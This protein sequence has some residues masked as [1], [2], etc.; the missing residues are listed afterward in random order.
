MTDSEIFPSSYTTYRKDRNARGGGVFILVHSSLKSVSVNIDGD[1]CEAVWCRVLLGDGT[2]LA[3]GSFYRPPGSTSPVSFFQLSNTLLTLHATYIILAGDFNMP[4]VEW[5]SYQPVICTSSLLYT[6]FREMINA[7]SL[8]QFVETPTRLGATSANVLDLFF[9]N[10]PNLVS[11]VITLP[12]ISDHDVVLAKLSY[13]VMK[14]QHTQ[15]RKVYFYEKGDYASLSSELDAFFPEFLSHGPSMNVDSFWNLFKTKILSLTHTFIPSRFIS[16]KRRDDKRWMNR[17]LRVMVN[18]RK[19][20][21]R[22]YCDSPALNLYSE[23]KKQ[24]KNLSKEIRK[25]KMAYLSTL[26]QRLK[27]NP[28]EVWK[29]VKSNRNTGV[30]LPEILDGVDYGKDS[31]GKANCFNLYFQSVFSSQKTRHAPFQ[32]SSNLTRMDDIEISQRGIMLL[33]QKVKLTSAPGPD[34]ISNYI[35]KNCAAS[36]APYLVVLFQKSLESGELPHDWKSANVVPIHK[37]GDRSKTCNYRPISLTSVS[38]KIL[39]HVIYT[40]LISHLQNNNFFCPTQHGFR[41]GFSCETQLVEFT[42]DISASLNSAGQVDCIFLDFRKAFDL[43]AHDLLLQKL[44]LLNIPTTLLTWIEAYL[45]ERK[46]CVVCDGI[47]SVSVGVTSG[48]PQ[49]SVLGPLLFLIF[50]NDLSDYISSTVRL[51]ADDCCVY[52]TISSEADAVTLQHDLNSVYSWCQKWNM[53]LNLSKCNLVRFTKKKQFLQADYFLG[54]TEISA[55]STYKYLGVIFSTDLSWNTH[56]NYIAAKASRTLNFLR[57]NFKDAPVKLKETLYISSV[58]PIL[59]YACAAWDPHTKLN[60]EE[61]ERVQKRAARFVS[62]DYNFQKRSSGLRDKLG[63]PLLENRRKYLRLSF[64]YNVLNNNTGIQKE[65]Y[66][67]E[68]SYISA[69]TD[70][71]LKAREYSCRINAFKYSFFPRTVHDWNGL[72]AQIATAPPTYFLTALQNHVLI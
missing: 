69:R 2:S 24:T 50:I 8:F 58:R 11:S 62:G 40:Q 44:S 67:K 72:P 55:V 60:V 23:M 36:V 3:V 21:F 31:R 53:A 29:Y 34:N 27:T 64:F 48:V 52:R 51:Y 43:V 71:P 20:L 19:S 38:C 47:S 6:A 30:T 10:D 41:S 1:S 25:A 45:M 17:Q 68:P 42:H 5:S 46:Q 33:L 12:G 49:G 13:K 35:L 59:E 61:L 57:R 37:S 63:W 32:T 70:H 22:R 26:G 18:R 15:P 65:K 9:C 28:K 16:A 4:S 7:H 56:V 66:I 54:S 14:R 39:E